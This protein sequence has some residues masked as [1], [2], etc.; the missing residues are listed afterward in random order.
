MTI[1]RQLK[2]LAQSIYWRVSCYLGRH[3]TKL[4]K[5]DTF[6]HDSIDPVTHRWVGI[7]HGESI[8]TRRCHVCDYTEYAYGSNLD[9]KPDPIIKHVVEEVVR[10]WR[11][12]NG[13]RYG[14]V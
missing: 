6:I 13:K 9:A 8:Q 7:V 11:E 4:I 10:Q 1:Y 5:L 12:R 3:V 2:Q 14:L